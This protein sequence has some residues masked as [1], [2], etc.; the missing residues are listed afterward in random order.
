MNKPKVAVKAY[1][2]F[3]VA[4]PAVSGTEAARV[5]GGPVVA[6][7]AYTRLLHRLAPDAD[8]LWQE[9]QGLVCPAIGVLVLDDTTLD[10]PGAQQMGLLRRHWLG[11][12]H[13][14]G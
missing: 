5:H 8:T 4:S 6:H 14:V 2:P 3:L 10:K 12:H 7:D 13:A 1:I 9:A 11:K